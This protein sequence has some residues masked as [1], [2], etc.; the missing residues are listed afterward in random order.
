MTIWSN[1]TGNIYI[2]VQI[3]I[4]PAWERG[5]DMKASVK[6]QAL[7]LLN[8]PSMTRTLMIISSEPSIR[9]LL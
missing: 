4:G 2:S 1:T 9:I 7:N 5:T 8:L 3:I 6:R